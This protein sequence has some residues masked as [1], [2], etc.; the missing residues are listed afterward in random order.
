MA[1]AMNAGS[2]STAYVVNPRVQSQSQSQLKKSTAYS[3]TL[4]CRGAPVGAYYYKQG[5]NV[6][7]GRT[8]FNIS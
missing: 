6:A 3:L 2:N 8:W 5:R 1:Q 7:Q 4:P